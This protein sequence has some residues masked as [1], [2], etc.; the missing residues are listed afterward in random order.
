[1]VIN[2]FEKNAVSIFISDVA[3]LIYDAF[4]I[5]Y[6]TYAPVLSSYKQNS[7]SVFAS[8][9]LSAKRPTMTKQKSAF[10]TSIKIYTQLRFCLAEEKTSKNTPMKTKPTSPEYTNGALLYIPEGYVRCVLRSKGLKTVKI[11]FTVFKPMRA[12]ATYKGCNP[13]NTSC[14]SQS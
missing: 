12:Y 14:L 10:R 3:V 13:C 9:A 5:L 4:F 1:M 2:R 11:S 7:P 6:P 8:S